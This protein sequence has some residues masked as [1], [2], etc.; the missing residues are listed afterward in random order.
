M[1][2]SCVSKK[3]HDNFSRIYGIYG[4]MN[5]ILSFGVDTAWRKTAAREV[6]GYGPAKVL[7]VATGT[8]DLAIE[9]WKE[10][11]RRGLSMHITGID[12]NKD[13]LD[14]ARSR[15]ARLGIAN[16]SMKEMDAMR[17]EYPNGSFDLV[18]SGF[19]I[20]N[21]DDLD[22]FIKQVKR[23]LRPGGKVVLLDMA[24]PDGG[25]ERLF[26]RLYLP[27]MNAF[28]SLVDREAYGWL[29]RSIRHF[30][31]KAFAAK[32]RAAGFKN[33]K[34]R[35]LPSGVAYILTATR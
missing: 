11:G 17:M 33:V 34:I 7:D 2:L 21:F 30:D 35:Q 9:I 3:I 6:V 19:A 5:H 4:P 18:T 13:M 10:A 28:G 31:K 8:G 14:V 26:F 22:L 15:A 29:V 27:V 23:V 32:M 20:R 12:F 24:M 16:S 25:A 1:V